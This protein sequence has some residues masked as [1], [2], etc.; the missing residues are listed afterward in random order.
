[1]AT[2]N[3]VTSF[4]ATLDRFRVGALD[5]VLMAKHLATLIRSGIP[6]DESLEI[7]AEEASTARLRKV[8]LAVRKRVEAGATLYE[9][10]AGFP[11]IF[12]ALFV[13]MV[14]VG[15]ESGTLEENL[16]YVAEQLEH[17]YDIRQ[18]VKGAAAYP[19]L[20]LV[21]AFVMGGAMSFF[22][23]PRLVPLFES[24]GVELPLP[25]RIVLAVSIFFVKYGTV[26]FVGAALGL[27]GLRVLLRTPAVRPYWHNVLLRIPT[28]GR[29]V[30]DLN[31][32]RFTRTLGILLR[33]GLPIVDALRITEETT[34]NWVY[35]DLVD[36]AANEVERGVPLSEAMMGV[37]VNR[38]VLPVIVPRM[39]GVGERTGT[40]D[41]AL[42]NLAEFYEKEVDGATKTMSTIIEPL[43]IIVI[44]LVVALI[45]IAIISPIYQLTGEVRSPGT[46][47]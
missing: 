30:L 44:G 47:G 10:L 42:I 39:I 7:L 6:L 46:G 20:V 5:R 11:S 4:S 18:K 38:K 23:L 15:E 21:L 29:I 9:S 3:P 31:M 33:S 45:A 24:L 16:R 13:Q 1:M 19:I 25:T 36:R 43:L 8:I 35:R 28:V 22:I 12:N 32:A 2:F 34:V 17:D 14:R 41:E 37:T 40:M 27:L 26:F